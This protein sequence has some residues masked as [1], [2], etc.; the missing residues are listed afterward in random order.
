MLCESARRGLRP[1]TL[2]GPGSIER[3]HWAV[4]K[5]FG[6]LMPLSQGK[7]CVTLAEQLTARF[8]SSAHSFFLFFCFFFNNPQADVIWSV[9]SLANLFG[10]KRGF[11]LSAL[12]VC[13][14][15]FELGKWLFVALLRN[16]TDS[17]EEQIS[18][19]LM[20]T[21]LI[22]IH[23]NKWC[24]SCSVLCTADC[25]G[26]VQKQRRAPAKIKTKHVKPPNKTPKPQ[27]KAT[28]AA[29]TQ[30][31]LTQVHVH[32]GARYF[33]CGLLA[34][35]CCFVYVPCKGAKEGEV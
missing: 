10:S 34:V 6:V 27:N 29:R 15:I 5:E 16:S 35:C 18:V 22:G 9:M 20:H 31:L 21:S 7:I 24:I 17:S 12:I 11:V 32:C 2:I 33:S 28:P 1:C 13:A 26:D 25:Q 30:T 4:Q 3:L 23:C 14:V 19:G 8:P